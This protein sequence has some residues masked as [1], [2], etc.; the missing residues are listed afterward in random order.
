MRS[1]PPEHL[2][3]GRR[4]AVGTGERP[5][6]KIISPGH[7]DCR[8]Y[9]EEMETVTG[10]LTNWEG[11]F[12][13]LQPDRAVQNRWASAVH[14][15]DRLEPVRWLTPGLVFREWWR[16]VI[17][18]HRRFWAGLAAVWV[19]ILAGNFSLHDHSPNPCC[20]IFADVAGN[21]H[22]VQRPAKNSGRVV[23]GSFRGTRCGATQILSTGTPNGKRDDI[24]CLNLS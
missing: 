19:V 16:D 2:P 6:L 3:P 9:C 11:H 7:A 23:D 21:G 20:E 8:K 14:A 13:P 1:L 17:R 18:P 10:L 5:G 15:A 4:L 22:I 12:T 24:D